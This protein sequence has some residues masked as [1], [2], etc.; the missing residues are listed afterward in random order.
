[1]SNENLLRILNIFDTSEEAEVLINALRNA[2]HIVRDFRVEDEED[3]IS[4][5]DE[6]PI[7]II[8]AK[9]KLDGFPAKQA[10][11]ALAHQS[12]DIPLI[13]ITPP[14]K[15]Y[16]A[17]DA[18]KAGAKD[19][20]GED[21]TDRLKHIV[22][23]EFA[24]LTERRAL[25]RSEQ[26]LH[27]TEKRAKSLIDS[28]RDAISYVHD[29][30]HIYANTSYLEMFG[31]TE[32]DDVMGLPIMDM[33]ISDDHVKLK[34]FLRGYA[35]GET[36]DSQLTVHGHH[37]DG[38]NFKIRMEFSPASYEGEACTQIIIRS[39]SDNKE[40]EEKL[41]AMSK[42]DLLTNLYNQNYFVEHLDQVL[43]RT[44]EG[45]ARG[46]L[47]LIS[48]DAFQNIRQELGMSAGDHMLT[49]I[50]KLL[51]SKLSDLG[52]L[53]RFEGAVFILSVMNI[54]SKQAEQYAGKICNL[55]N[56]H[57]ADVGT[58]T[59]QTT[60]SIGITLLNETTSNSQ[61]CIN[62]AE[63]GCNIAN[64]EGGNRY[65]VYNPAI[66]EMA[67]Q[68]QVNVWTAKIK[69]ALKDNKFKLLFQPIVSL[70][71]EPGA[72][73]EILVRML[74]E[75]G[76]Q[77]LPNE[78]IP[79]AEQ[80][81]LMNYIDRWVIANALMLLSRRNKE[82]I[83]T[84]LFIK[85]STA[86]IIDPDFL[87]WVIG[88]I[89]SLKLDTDSLVFEVTEENA[90]NHLKQAKVL[91]DG[92]NELHCRTTLE[93]FGLEQNTYQALKHIHVN[94]I[95][96]HMDLIHGLAQNVENQEK[97]KAIAEY[98]NSK[99]IQTIAAFVE[100]ANSLAVLWQCA[101]DFIQGHF[102]QHPD[103]KMDYDFDEGF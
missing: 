4:T 51:N 78:F 32:I 95:K 35:K 70:H 90:L 23:R 72:H 27:E 52:M 82:G 55:I 40:L 9:Q 74:D 100:D 48:L 94:Y 77:M 29:G 61:D 22:K 103:T 79:A 5:L 21:Q 71:G 6:N 24:N 45:Q 11:E 62:R 2:G 80:A 16:S 3:M 59:V 92:L 41:N 38:N 20:I 99:N 96:V 17:L 87:P 56:N 19:A 42:M 89:K 54:D 97:V 39:Q 8:L 25:R 7:D 102:L 73:Y 31:Y 50:A 86:S 28:S 10:V 88:R 57:L 60:A 36:M 37:S 30:M 65:H 43:S 34:E 67:E 75:T 44:V 84:R 13:V 58:K 83:K 93:N 69:S 49:D 18:L 63:K 66:E 1:M 33:V 64:S 98:A 47:L 76:Q 12:R 53:A 91:I 15:D 14:G 101:V 46:A 68:E 26:M 85:L 81:G